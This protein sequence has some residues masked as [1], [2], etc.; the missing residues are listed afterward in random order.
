MR[1]TVSEEEGVT[2]VFFKREVLLIAWP[3]IYT[4]HVGPPHPG[5]V[6]GIGSSVLE[7][8]VDDTH[9]KRDRGGKVSVNGLAIL[10]V[11]KGV[12]SDQRS[13]FGC[14]RLSIIDG[15]PPRQLATA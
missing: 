3:E 12:P 14:G 15:G 4:P 11:P 10:V 7:C 6:D 13:I 5:N 1:T 8:N 2:F 9:R